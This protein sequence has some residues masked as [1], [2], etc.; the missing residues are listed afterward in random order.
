MNLRFTRFDDF[1]Y[2]RLRLSAALI[3]G[4]AFFLLLPVSLERRLLYAWDS[5]AL[6]LLGLSWWAILSADT[7]YT[8]KSATRQDIGG[9]WVGVL[10]LLSSAISTVVVV[11]IF[12]RVHKEVSLER[13]LLSVVAIFASWLLVH[14]TYTF[15]YARKYYQ[16][17]EHQGALS[18]PDDE[19]PDF[20]DFAYFSLNMGM[21]FQVAD[22]VPES[23][24]MR[25]TVMGHALL[26]YV[27]GTGLVAVT[28]NLLASV[29]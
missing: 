18:F 16:E 10:V 27:F 19:E 24:A 4:L 26:S 22:I 6:T 1:D 23:R 17:G 15:R 25:R 3:V 13:L 2:P 20:R 8:R 11:V 7:D 14:T 29:L 12:P 28:I 5:A 9:H 21:C